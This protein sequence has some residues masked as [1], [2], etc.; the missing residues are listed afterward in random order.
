MAAI[1]NIDDA[2]RDRIGEAVKAAEGT[3]SGEIVTIIADR[4]DRY[5]DV[6][7]W[8]SAIVAMLALAVYAMFPDYYLNL[9]N[10]FTGSWGDPDRSEVLELAL[11]ITGL[12]FVGM[13]LLLQWMPLRLFLTPRRVKADRVRGRALRYFK[14]SAEKRTIGRTG[15]LIY[16][17]SAEHMAE[18]VADKSIHSKI[19]NTMWG[20]AM[21]KLV[22]GARNDNL[23]DGMVAAIGDIGVLLSEYLPRS[24]DDVNELP[25]RLIEL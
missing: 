6:A 12:K 24:D 19:D 22:N 4:S 16:L 14:V 1:T 10:R 8:W 17:S 2:G 5:A 21:A 15:I 7:L 3:T 23:A 25:D 20:E 13:R 18:I 11:V 9:I